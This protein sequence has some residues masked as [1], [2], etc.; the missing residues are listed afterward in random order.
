VGKGQHDVL[1][2]ICANPNRTKQTLLVVEKD[3]DFENIERSGAY[4]GLYYLLGDTL[5]PFGKEPDEK[6]F[7]RDL[8]DIVRRRVEA[9]ELQEVIL[10]FSVNADGEHTTR[11]LVE[12]LAPLSQQHGIRVTIPARGFSTGTEI[13]YPDAETIKNALKNRA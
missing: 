13:E 9:H 7:A 5:P 12:L 6:R 8:L 2:S 4:D 3:V 11:R 1:C 10:A